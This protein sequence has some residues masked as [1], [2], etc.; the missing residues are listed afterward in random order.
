MALQR[1]QRRNRRTSLPNFARWIRVYC[2]GYSARHLSGFERR[3]RL[4]ALLGRMSKG[5]AG[6]TAGAGELN[7]LSLLFHLKQ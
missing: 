7:G 2:A 6:L 5:F 1:H 3:A 4:R